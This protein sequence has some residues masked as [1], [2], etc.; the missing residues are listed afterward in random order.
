VPITPATVGQDPPV[1]FVGFVLVVVVLLHLYVYRR[2]VHDV[3]HG[4]RSRLVGALLIT[5]LGLATCAALLTRGVLHPATARPLH[6]VGY[7]WL[8]VVLYLAFLLGIGELVRLAVR[9]VRGRPSEERRRFLSRGLAG[10]AAMTAVGTVVYGAAGAR[11]PRVERREVLLDRLDPAFDGFAI[12]AISD[13]HLGPLVDGTDLAGFVAMI[14]GTSPDVVAVVGDLVDG[15][16]AELGSYAAPLADIAAPTYFVTGNHE[17]YSGAAGWVDF[18]PTLGVRVLR[19]ER[20]EIRRG[21]AVLHIAGCDDRTAA[22]SG[23]PGHGFDL[24]AALRGRDGSQPVVLLCHQPVMVDRAARAGVDLQISGHTHG[25]Q[26]WPLTQVA[27]VDQPV[28]AGLARVG[29]TWLY[30]TRGTGFWGP[31]A[32]VGSPPEI[33]LLTL[34]ARAAP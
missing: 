8:A 33:T 18:L 28:L 31:P 29:P 4:R 3:V 5:V 2:A 10:G 27:L 12:A 14:N 1:G 30:V 13:I 34:R 19:N 26:L 9:F 21:D 20:E 11:Q 17:Y 22:A 7:F 6:L 16:V 23:V 32:R 15:T 25:G 24:D